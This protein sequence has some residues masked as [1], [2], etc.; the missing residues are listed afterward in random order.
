MWKGIQEKQ[1][2]KSKLKTK[3]YIDEQKNTLKWCFEITPS[4]NSCLCA[5]KYCVKFDMCS[6]ILK[7]DVVASL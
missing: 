5:L 7:F 6:A 2:K 1:I 3:L 4:T